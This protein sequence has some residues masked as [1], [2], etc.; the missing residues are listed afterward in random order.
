MDWSIDW[1]E[2]AHYR[3]GRAR[4]ANKSGLIY[5]AVALRIAGW[6]VAAIAAELGVSKQ[7]VSVI[8]NTY[9]LAGRDGKL[10]VVRDDG[11]A[12]DTGEPL[13]AAYALPSVADTRPYMGPFGNVVTPYHRDVENY[14]LMARADEL[15]GAV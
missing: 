12:A 8:C 1:H 13:L 15:A 6:T 14:G 11:W 10:L 7:R 5:A 3:K 4:T 9:R 2:L